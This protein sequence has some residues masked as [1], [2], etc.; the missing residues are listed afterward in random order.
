MRKGIF[1]ERLLIAFAFA[2][3]LHFFIIQMMM[4]SIKSGLSYKESVIEVEYLNPI[5]RND[6]DVMKEKNQEKQAKKREEEFKKEKAEDLR[7]EEEVKKEEGQIVYIGET[8][9]EKAPEKYRFLAEHN[10]V[11]EKESKSR[12]QDNKYLNPAPRP[13]VGESVAKIVNKGENKE[14]RPAPD[15][16][17][18]NRSSGEDEKE[19]NKPEN[20]L[21]L[22]IPK[23]LKSESINVEESEN[24]MIKNKE[25]S[26]ELNGRD[27]DFQFGSSLEKGEELHRKRLARLFPQDI[28]SGKYSGGPFNDWLRDVEESDST[29]LNAKEYKYA[30]FFNRIKK[31]VSQ[32]WNPSDVILKYD[33]YGNV[34]GNKDRLT[35]VRVKIDATGNLKDVDV[36][37]SSGVE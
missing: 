34:Y 9:S 21:A 35:I 10:S 25:H 6:F 28:F 3:L 26:E 17:L 19:D 15:I 27:S 4:E 20:R 31:S 12:Y 18:K 23:L 13:Q 7:K 8:E 32:Y 29:F 33:P 1:T 11:T 36:S 16:I 37:Q 2:L 24:G 30:T 5:V 22:K 14:K